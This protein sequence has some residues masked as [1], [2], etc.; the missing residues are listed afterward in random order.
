LRAG[1]ARQCV[2]PLSHVAARALQ[3]MTF[4]ARA[5]SASGGGAAPDEQLAAAPPPLPLRCYS[6]D[7]SGRAAATDNGTGR[8]AGDGA[9]APSP[10]APSAYAASPSASSAPLLPRVLSFGSFSKILAPALRCG[11]AGP[12]GAGAQCCIDGR[13]RTAGATCLV[14]YSRWPTEL[15]PHCPS[16]SLCR[17]AGS[18]CRTQRCS[19]GSRRTA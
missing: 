3:L 13:E 12:E 14:V 4:D 9:S 6:P 17:A 18:R 8:L 5:P 11:C 15:R 1:S 10:S 16:T 19:S 7:G 2:E